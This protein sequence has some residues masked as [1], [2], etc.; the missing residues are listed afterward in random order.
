MMSNETPASEPLPT[1]EALPGSPVEVSPG[2]YELTVENTVA[3]ADQAFAVTE[4]RLAGAVNLSESAGIDSAELKKSLETSEA[5]ARAELSKVLTASEIDAAF[6]DLESIVPEAPKSIEYADT[7]KLE[8]ADTLQIQSRDETPSIKIEASEE[9]PVLPNQYL[10]E[11]VVGKGLDGKLVSEIDGLLQKEMGD[12]YNPDMTSNQVPVIERGISQIAKAKQ[13]G[14]SEA[15]IAGIVQDM[16]KEVPPQSLQTLGGSQME[17][18]MAV[19]TILPDSWQTAKMRNQLT[20][21]DQ[22]P[23]LADLQEKLGNEQ[24]SA[25]LKALPKAITDDEAMMKALFSKESLSGLSSA[26]QSTEDLPEAL[27]KIAKL[28]KNKPYIIQR[29][30]KNESF[31]TVKALLDSYS[32]GAALAKPDVL[33][34]EL[35]RII[36]FTEPKGDADVAMHAFKH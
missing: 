8:N 4:A 27:L 6:S 34:R 20:A 32:L 18:I 1:T 7:L 2:V 25:F 26:L 33:E 12:I 28:A 29:S 5:K 13:L 31:Q 14:M 30:L 21:G 22:L 17:K 9:Y 35:K 16:R 15:V 19:N 23:V 10:T 3:E 36:D 11:L 24:V